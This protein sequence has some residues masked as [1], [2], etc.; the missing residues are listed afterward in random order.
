MGQGL[1]KVNKKNILQFSD[2][3]LIYEIGINSS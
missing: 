1:E 2:P 3:D